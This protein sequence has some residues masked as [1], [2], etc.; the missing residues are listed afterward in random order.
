MSFALAEKRRDASLVY[1][2]L[3]EN[4]SDLEKTLGVTANRCERLKHFSKSS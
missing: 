2:E 1:L 4:F 3:L